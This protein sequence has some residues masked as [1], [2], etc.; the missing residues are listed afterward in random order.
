MLLKKNEVIVQSGIDYRKIRR[1]IE[2]NLSLEGKLASLAKQQPNKKTLGF[3]KLNLTIYNRFYTTDQK[4]LYHWIMTTIG[5][6][7]VLFDSTSLEASAEIMHE[8]MVSKGYLLS[9]VK[10]DYTIKRRLATPHYYV[11]PGPLYTIDSVFFPPDTSLLTAI[12][13]TAKKNTLLKHENA[14]DADII[15][16]EQLRLFREFQNQGYYHFLRDF[17]Y[18]EADTFNATRTANV[19]VKIQPAASSEDFQRYYVGNIYV[20]PNYDPGEE[21]QFVHHDTLLFN[22]EYFI[23]D[24]GT[25]SPN[26]LYQR[27]LIAKGSLYS[28]NDYDFTLNGLA[29]L[30]VFKFISIHYEEKPDH[31]L[32]CII[33]LTPAKKHA[34]TT[35]IEA[36]NIEDNVGTA[37]KLSYKDKNVF[38]SGNQFDISLNAGTQIPVF[39]KDSLIFNVS[40][41]LNFYLPR[42]IPG[43]YFRTWNPRTRFSALAN[44]YQQTNIYQLNNYS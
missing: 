36:S 26:A 39:N 19:Y 9:S 27:I 1:N 22:N 11:T 24:S 41:Q 23:D 4:G 10:N 20:F 12:V 13:D 21:L 28:R 8:Y 42:F 18:F 17:I 33:Y 5:E 35:E 38:H 2:E 15:G 40:G 7:P 37:V 16:K 34:I 25:I 14:F 30:G 6:P 31:V 3:F 29:D 44:Y 32:D 43:N